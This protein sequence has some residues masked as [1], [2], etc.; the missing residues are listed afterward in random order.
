MKLKVV[1][2]EK[3]KTFNKEVFTL[4]GGTTLA[5][6]MIILASPVITRVYTPEDFG[7][8]GIYTAIMTFFAIIATLKYELAIPLPE[9]DQDAATVL[10]L[11]LLFSLITVLVLFAPIFIWSEEI[12]LLFNTP[13]IE[14]FLWTIPVGV[15]FISLYNSLSYWAIRKKEF[16]VFSV[17]KISQSISSIIAQISL[18]LLNFGVLGMISGQIIGQSFG[19]SKLF[20]TFDKKYFSAE[21]ASIRAL[22]KVGKEYIKFPKFSVI[23]MAAN[24]MSTQIP[25]LLFASL[26]SPA[27]AGFY[28]LAQ[29]VI[30]TPMDLIGFS[31]SKVFHANAVI[32]KRENNLDKLGLEVLK[33][34]IKTSV[35][36]LLLFLIVAP[37][38]FTLIFG[39]EWQ[40][41]GVYVQMLIPWLILVFITAPL[42]NI[43]LIIQ[44]QKQG[45][46]FNLLLLILR[47]TA[48]YIGYLFSDS[49]LSVILFGTVS[50]LMWL[51]Y[52]AWIMKIL[53]I[54]F[55]LWVQ[56]LFKEIIH[57]LPFI[58]ILILTKYLAEH[59]L[60]EIY[61]NVLIFVLL[62]VF[63]LIILKNRVLPIWK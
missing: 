3:N 44:K 10:F 60:S 40:S 9:K 43:I 56:I 53:K 37:E 26:F 57:A 21:R 32:A 11:A 50:F 15:F 55:S 27:I 25:P 23:S 22:R 47:V 2:K 52:A 24:S 51:A 48:I 4:A 54:R 41:A 31:I 62:S 36:P 28:V 13:E 1:E 20:K 45:L 63:G 6:V 39:D 8:L 12:A 5:Q 38:I 33:K 19:I 17:T 34:L 46:Y 18:G 16:K 58:F 30:T 59:Y 61:S 14:K 29:R 42:S 35:T 49:L 7:L